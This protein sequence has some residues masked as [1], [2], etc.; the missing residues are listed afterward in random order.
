MTEKEGEELVRLAQAKGLVLMVGHS[1]G[2]FF[3]CS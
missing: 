2:G 1:P 3:R